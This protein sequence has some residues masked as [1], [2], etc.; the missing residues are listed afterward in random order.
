MSAVKKILNSLSLLCYNE[1]MR[2]KFDVGDLVQVKHPQGARGIVIETE[3]INNSIKYPEKTA[4]HTD[5]YRCKVQFIT[6]SEV[7]WVRAK[8]LEHLSKINQ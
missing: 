1:D 8:W 7:K 4:W 2:Q 3:P 5:E 6:S